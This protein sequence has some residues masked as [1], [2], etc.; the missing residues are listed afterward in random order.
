[1]YEFKE[2]NLFPDSASAEEQLWEHMELHRRRHDARSHTGRPSREELELEREHCLMEYQRTGEV[3]YSIDEILRGSFRAEMLRN[4]R[5]ID[6]RVPR[7]R[8]N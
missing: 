3:L 8:E 7:A 1:M 5:R 4:F 2:N 6:G